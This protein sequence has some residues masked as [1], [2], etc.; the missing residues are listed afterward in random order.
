MSPFLNKLSMLVSLQE[1]LKVTSISNNVVICLGIQ[2]KMKIPR[3]MAK[4]TKDPP[5]MI[6]S[7]V[8][9]GDGYPTFHVSL[10]INQLILHNSMLDYGSEVNVMPYKV[11]NQLELT[12]T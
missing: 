7:V 2:P 1:L 10:E 11:M 5:I 9:K 4:I 6:Q 3:R 8:N 12:T